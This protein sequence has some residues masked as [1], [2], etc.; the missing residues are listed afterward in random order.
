MDGRCRAAVR[1]QDP[2]DPRDPLDPLDPRD[3][4]MGSFLRVLGVNSSKM[5]PGDAPVQCVFDFFM[6]APY[7]TPTSEIIFRKIQSMLQGCTETALGLKPMGLS[8]WA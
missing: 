3:P 7:R 8:P 4:R 5:E 6:T 1:G 2:L